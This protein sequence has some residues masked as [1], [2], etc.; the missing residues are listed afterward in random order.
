[1]LLEQTNKLNYWDVVIKP[2]R[3]SLASRSLVELSRIL[4]GPYAVIDGVPIVAA[5]MATGTFKM[6]DSLSKHNMF[7]AVA[8]HNNKTWNEVGPDDGY[9]YFNHGFYTI[10]MNLDDLN[11]YFDTYMKC[12]GN[13]ITP[14]LCID[15]ANGYTEEFANFVSKA[16][17]K[18]MD[19][20]IVAG[21]VATPEMTEQLIISG[22]DMVKV[23]IGAGS[24]CTTRLKTGVGYPQLS[25]VIECADA[26]HGIGGLIMADGGIRSPADVAKAFC[27]NADMV[28]I[29][30]MFAGTDECDGEIITRYYKTGELELKYEDADGRREFTEV[31]QE[32]KFK[33]FYGMSS[34]HA[35]KTHLGV[36]K[37][38]RASEGI[39]SEVPYV[40]SVDSIIKDL[41]GGLRSTGTYI[42][43]DEIKHFGKCA[44]LVKTS[45]IHDKF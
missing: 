21:N 43:A 13:Q 18:Y 42:G 9:P 7:V 30:G 29:G 41:L 28:M 8:K 32:R 44:T 20:F 10:G 12:T 35:Q 25:A 33:L 34:D 2:K 16:R 5:N 22:A 11:A 24:Q 31:I 40:G 3:S 39:V 37:D 45:R 19:A 15:I 6:I 36:I 27:A 14:K 26:A 1:M 23:G 38:Y 17:E 4:R